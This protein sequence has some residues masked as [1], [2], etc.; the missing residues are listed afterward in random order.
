MHKSIRMKFEGTLIF[1]PVP[2]NKRK[3]KEID[4]SLVESIHLNIGIPC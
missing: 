3:L 1:M 2:L 4:A